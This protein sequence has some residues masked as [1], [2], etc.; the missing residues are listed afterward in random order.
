MNNLKVL[1][2]STTFINIFSNWFIHFLKIFI[3]LFSIPL[4]LDVYNKVEYGSYALYLAFISFAGIFDFGNFNNI[5]RLTIKYKKTGDKIKYHFNLSYVLRNILISNLLIFIT[6]FII[7]YFR[8]LIFNYDLQQDEMFFLVLIFALIN[9]IFFNLLQITLGILQG[10]QKNY[11][12]NIGIFFGIIFISIVYIVIYYKEI[13]FIKFIFLNTIVNL[14]A[15]IFNIYFIRKLNLFKG[16]K[17]NKLKFE[18][19]V[20]SFQKNYFLLN[21]FGFFTSNSDKFILAIFTNVSTA[22][23]YD[24]ISRPYYL[25]KAF[26][27]NFFSIYQ[28]KILSMSSEIQKGIISDTFKIFVKTGILILIFAY[29]FIDDFYLFWLKDET[30]GSIPLLSL[31]LISASVINLISGSIHRIFIMNHNIKGIRNVEIIG[32]IGNAL[33]SVLGAKYIAFYY[34]IFGTIF[35]VLLMLV[36][37]FLKG[38]NS[39]YLKFNFND[40]YKFTLFFILVGICL[41]YNSIIVLLILTIYTFFFLFSF[42]NKISPY[43]K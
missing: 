23:I 11:L 2:K 33:I 9:T 19:E 31:V 8:K 32:G 39:Q 29:F 12:H 14:I 36:Y 28:A 42:L 25:L 6:G 30:L 24:L 37:I 16:Y 35:Q 41:T 15:L 1:L 4:L 7:I 21:I 17:Y 3:V 43:L 10:Y 40:I 20:V 18:E 22:G 26:M 38:L 5:T 13:D 27:G 34:V